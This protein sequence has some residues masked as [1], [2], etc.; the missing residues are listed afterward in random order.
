MYPLL[1][2][3]ALMSCY[4]VLLADGA[5][6]ERRQTN[7]PIDCSPL[8]LE[9]N[10]TTTTCP[11]LNELSSLIVLITSPI[12]PE[13]NTD[14][15]RDWLEDT[16]DD[17]C[18]TD[19][20]NYAVQYYSQDCGWAFNEDPNSSINLYQNYFCGSR[21]GEYCLVEMMEYYDDTAAVL[22]Q[23]LQCNNPSNND[24]C[25]PACMEVLEDMHTELGCCA[26]NLFNNTQSQYPPESLFERCNLSLKPSDMCSG[27]LQTS[28]ASL[29]LLLVA[30]SLS[31]FC[32]S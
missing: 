29:L 20:L 12:R 4:S 28:I 31:T 14:A 6:A 15:Y 7:L 21:N 1:P 22:E 2:I 3:V 11:N 30:V 8:V 9:V 17:F 26:V 5:G 25:S 18:T 16:L 32:L 13:W 27:A 19:C 23:M 10:V 24:I